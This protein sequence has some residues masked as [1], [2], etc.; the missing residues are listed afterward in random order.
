MLG[1]L[2]AI[3]ASTFLNV[4]KGVQKWKVA[5]L[6]QGRRAFSAE[7]RKELGLWCVGLGMTAS[8]TV[9]YSFALKFTDKP[10]TVSALNG[11]GLIGLVVFARLVLKETVGLKEM[12]GAVLIVAGTALM[13]L[14]DQPPEAGQVFESSGFIISMVA[15][16]AV[17]APLAIYSWRARRW[18]GVVFGSLAGAMIGAAMVLGDVALVEADG[19]VLGQFGGPYV[20]IALLIG[21]G[22]LAM[23]QLAFWR[24]PAMVVVPT[25][26]SFV[27]FTPVVLQYFTFGTVLH[28]VQLLAVGVI[29]AGVVRLT[30]GGGTGE[31]GA[32]VAVMEVEGLRQ[33]GA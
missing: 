6:G 23:T 26:N 16:G 9:L 33:P 11:V 20:Y 28:P 17:Y 8:A 18:H 29:I 24:A 14:F 31:A 12:L 10:S 27:I 3:A 19:D 30:M 4:G 32:E 5:V 21:N 7:H 1:I 25:T 15:L 13:G 22:A 2:L